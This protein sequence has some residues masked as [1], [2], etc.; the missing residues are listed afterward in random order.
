MESLIPDKC[1]CF[2]SFFFLSVHT[3]SVLVSC[4][5]QFCCLQLACVC[6]DSPQFGS[7]IQGDGPGSLCSLRS[8]GQSLCDQAFK[9][10]LIFIF[11][12]KVQDFNYTYERKTN[13]IVIE[14]F[15]E[16]VPDVKR[17]GLG[18]ELAR[19]MATQ[20]MRKMLKCPKS[21]CGQ[22]IFYFEFYTKHLFM[23]W[24]GIL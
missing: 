8:L 7:H 2:F 9:Y 22:T 20:S 13:L 18:S 19:G 24:K 5:A 12:I 14:Q 21:F 4:P 3:T 23:L 11:I 16:I 6:V 10:I 15:S 17:G 1:T